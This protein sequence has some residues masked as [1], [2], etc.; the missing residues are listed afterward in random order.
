MA[1]AWIG[2]GLVQQAAL[3]MGDQSLPGYKLHL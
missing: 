1:V 3:T 2:D